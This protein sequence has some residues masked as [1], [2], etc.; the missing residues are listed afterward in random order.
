M[1]RLLRTAD[2]ASLAACA[3]LLRDRP[4]LLVK[5]KGPH[6]PS[7]WHL[8]ATTGTPAALLMLLG[9][10]NGADSPWASW[11]R[12]TARSELRALLNDCDEWGQTPLML[13][14]KMGDAASVALLMTLV[15]RGRGEV[16]WESVQRRDLSSKRRRGCL[17]SCVSG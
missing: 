9:L 11:P 17:C 15:R 8:A 5:R 12:A 4:E 7:L 6:Q 3:A 10:V 2:E 13:A 1:Q 16:L 14:A